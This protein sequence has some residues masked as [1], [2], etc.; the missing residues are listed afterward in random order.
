MG[1][2]GGSRRWKVGVKRDGSERKIFG[3]KKISWVN[4]V[5]SVTVVGCRG[6][7]EMGGVDG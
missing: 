1:Q 6:H 3:A 5:G 7:E 4:R 2:W